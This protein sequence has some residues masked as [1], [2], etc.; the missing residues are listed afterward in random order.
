FIPWAEP[1]S[2]PRK[3]KITV[4]QLLNHTSG[5]S[6]E[7]T[8]SHNE[9]TWE[10]ILGHTGDER[11]AK[12]AFDPGTGCGYSTLALHHAALVCENVTGKPYDAFAIEALFKPLGIEHWSFTTFDGDAKHGRHVS[13]SMGMPA[14]DLARIGYC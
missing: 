2:D 7:A 5:I 11:T 14:R 6:P 12:L 4:K 13:H 9:G 10:Y 3:S 8:G 1:L